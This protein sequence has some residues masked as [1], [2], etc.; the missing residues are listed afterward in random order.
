MTLNEKQISLIRK[1]TAGY[2]T[3]GKSIENQYKSVDSI[4]DL[5]IGTVDAMND[6]NL[7]DSVGLVS[8]SKFRNLK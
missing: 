8:L 4:F 2:P 5:T 3:V 7:I 1:N 6:F